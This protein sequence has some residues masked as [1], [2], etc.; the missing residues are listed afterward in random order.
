MTLASTGQGYALFIGQRDAQS[1]DDNGGRRTYAEPSTTFPN[2]APGN[3]PPLTLTSGSQGAPRLLKEASPRSSVD[4]FSIENLDNG[5]GLVHTPTD[6]LEALLTGS[7]SLW[8]HMIVAEDFFEADRSAIASFGS[9]DFYYDRDE[10]TMRIRSR[11]GETFSLDVSMFPTAQGEY[12]AQELIAVTLGFVTVAD[13]TN[14]RVYIN[15]ILESGASSNYAGPATLDA[16]AFD[17][18][19]TGVR[20]GGL[21]AGDGDTTPGWIA[22]EVAFEI[23]DTLGFSGQAADGVTRS[24]PS[25]INNLLKDYLASQY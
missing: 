6:D 25:H 23:G 21:G 19:T 1:V 9:I 22:T 18:N 7:N 3:R 2:L 4:A 12:S 16:A 17:M 20:I 8:L 10:R 11:N 15:G 5:G 14:F 24:G 13:P